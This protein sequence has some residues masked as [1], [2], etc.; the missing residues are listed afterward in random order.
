MAMIGDGATSYDL[1]KDG[2]PNEADA[3]SVSGRRLSGG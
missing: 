1:D 3:C 2:Q